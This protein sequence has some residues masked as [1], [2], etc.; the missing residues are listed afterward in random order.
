MPNAISA[1]SSS[2][3]LVTL[4]NKVVLAARP[5]MTKFMDFVTDF[6][7]DFVAPGSTLKIAVNSG[8][9]AGAFDS[10]TNNYATGK[11][12]ISFASVTLTHFVDS[13][14]FTDA[15]L[16]EV[17]E[18]VFSKAAA[19]CA[20]GIQ[21]A[22]ADAVDTAIQN[23]NTTATSL[24]VPHDGSLSKAD[25]AA[26]AGATKNDA[27]RCVLVLN[28]AY[29]AKAIAL[30]DADVYGGAEAI[31]QGRLDGGVFG[32]KAIQ[33]STKVPTSAVGVI[34]PEDALAVV[35]R[36][37]PCNK[38]GY[39]DYKLEADEE[40]GLAIGFRQG[41][42]QETGTN[43]IAAETAFGAAFADANNCEKVVV[44]AS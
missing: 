11:E 16:L 5:A 24:E 38:A 12:S 6:S 32:W 4:S 26:L 23:L 41:F 3:A 22:M 21:L 1:P 8:T 13:E 34:I 33:W 44:A 2:P 36:A 31:R 18:S 30:F 15:Q 14:T 39:I 20:R 7:A 43:F 10:S 28:R 35:A 37:V 29:W 40:T 42:T 9:K 17:P 19:G 27:A 25:I